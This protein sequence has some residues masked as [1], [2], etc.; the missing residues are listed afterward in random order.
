MPS[1]HY[2]EERNLSIAWGRGLRLAS[3]RGHSETVPLIVAI[4]GFDE[5]GN[6]EEENGIRTALEDLLVKEGKQSVETVA[7]TIFPRSLWN[8]AA[9]RELLYKRYLNILPRIQKATRKNSHG[10]YFERMISGGPKGAENQLDFGIGTYLGREGVRRSVLQVAVFDPN[11]DHSAAAQLGFP[12][13]Q[14]VTFAPSDEGLSVNAFYASQYMVERAYGNYLGLCRLGQ[15]IAHEMSLRLVRLTCLTGIAV[16]EISKTKLA[17]ASS[18][19]D[20]ALAE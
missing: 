5:Y 8:P 10:L 4:T 17:P 6:V 1:E 18:A 9:P 2:V 11:R 16:C 13:L 20:R 15:F 19:I 7:N 14:H 3:A 12:C